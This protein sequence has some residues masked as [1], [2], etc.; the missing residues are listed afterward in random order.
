MDRQ[1][2]HLQLDKELWKN[3]GLQS[4]KEDTTR[5]EIVTKALK[6]YLD[7]END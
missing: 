7:K 2:V 1:T 6:Q 5:R 3:V 4:I